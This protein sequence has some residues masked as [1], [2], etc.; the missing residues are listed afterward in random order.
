MEAAVC[1]PRARQDAEFAKVPE[2]ELEICG[3]A[4]GIQRP[5]PAFDLKVNFQKAQFDL[6]PITGSER[7]ENLALPNRDLQSRRYLPPV[8]EIAASGD[9]HIGQMARCDSQVVSRFRIEAGQRI[10]I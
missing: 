2:G 5:K 3:W 4:A 8:T 1:Q 9:L 10:E 7:D 6:V